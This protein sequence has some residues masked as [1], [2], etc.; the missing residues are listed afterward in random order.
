MFST[1][2]CVKFAKNFFADSSEGRRNEVT[3]WK[4]STF[5]K[6]FILSFL[7]KGNLRTL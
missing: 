4:C 3:V 5:Y 6:D 2:S 7:C 1:F